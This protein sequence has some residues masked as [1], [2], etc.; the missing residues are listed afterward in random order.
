M[1]P[2]RPL[3][4]P[5]AHSGKHA[6]ATGLLIVAV[7]PRCQ[8]REGHSCFLPVER[9]T[10][11]GSS[12]TE[13]GTPTAPSSATEAAS[14]FHCPVFP[15]PLWHKGRTNQSSNK[16]MN[17]QRNDYQKQLRQRV[18]R[19]L[20]SEVNTQCLNCGGA[21]DSGFTDEIYS[22]VREVAL[23]S[24]KNGVAVGR[25]QKG[26]PQRHQGS[27]LQNGKLRPAS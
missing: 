19:F 9:S 18:Q 23:E 10:G 16:R 7:T 21:L 6:T 24:Y 5:L 17:Q 22:L 20:D 25:K 8:T 3:C 2:K 1:W 11:L 13:R 26:A 27:A 12:L 14:G 15:A 4:F